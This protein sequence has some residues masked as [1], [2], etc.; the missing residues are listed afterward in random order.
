M[1][2]LIDLMIHAGQGQ[3]TLASIAERNGISPQYLEQV[4][5]GLRRGG[6]VNSI[7]GPNGGYVL[8]E[9]PAAISIADVVE[10]LEGTYLLEDEAI[11]KANDF[12]VETLQAVVIDGFNQ[13]TEAFLRRITL[14][15]L[16]RE[17][18]AKSGA[19]ENMYFI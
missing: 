5:A 17:Y 2:A 9:E 7:K 19:V 14:A 15:D 3:V 13:Q 16:L 11:G 8:A 4:F 6:I 12:I 1:R 10:A 18:E